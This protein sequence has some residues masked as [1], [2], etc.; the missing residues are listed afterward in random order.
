MKCSVTFLLAHRQHFQVSNALFLD[1]ILPS[2]LMQ[3]STQMSPYICQMLAA[4]SCSL[5]PLPALPLRVISGLCDV[6]AHTCPQRVLTSEFQGPSTLPH[7]CCPSSGLPLRYCHN[8]RLVHISSQMPHSVSPLSFSHLLILLTSHSS[9]S[10]EAS[11]P[12]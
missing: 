4:A 12:S 11:L 3:S 5:S 8:P 7:F 1:L 9:Q 2:P 10:P 6:A